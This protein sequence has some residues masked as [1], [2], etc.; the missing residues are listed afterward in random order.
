MERN[1]DEPEWRVLGLKPWDSA[2]FKRVQSPRKA[3]RGE[4]GFRA[5]RLIAVRGSTLD[6][7]AFHGMRGRR[8][9][10]AEGPAVRCPIMPGFRH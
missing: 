8:G 4:T 5:E 1:A 7:Q 3:K 2:S 10:S 9:L 6:G